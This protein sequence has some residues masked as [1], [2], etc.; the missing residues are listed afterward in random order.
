MKS[1]LFSCSPLS[2]LCSSCM[3]PAPVA[4]RKLHS[5]AKLLSMRVVEGLIVDRLPGIHTAPGAGREEP[6]AAVPKNDRTSYC[7][8]NCKQRSR[9]AMEIAIRGA[10]AFGSLGCVSLSRFRGLLR[11]PT[12]HPTWTG[13][14][15]SSSLKKDAAGGER[16]IDRVDFL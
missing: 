7:N 9:A 5:F 15:D 11:W 1:P 4:A 14:S 6:E 8:C 3:L 2:S 12:R 16:R 10:W 13:Q